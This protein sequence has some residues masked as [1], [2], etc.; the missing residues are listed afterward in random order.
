MHLFFI[1]FSLICFMNL[2]N[3]HQLEKH[4]GAHKHA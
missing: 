4:L 3:M 2:V 1:L